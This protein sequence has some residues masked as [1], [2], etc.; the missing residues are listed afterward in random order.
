[1][2]LDHPPPSPAAG[3]GAGAAARPAATGS[4]RS[5]SFREPCCARPRGCTM[6]AQRL[7]T[8]RRRWRANSTAATCRRSSAPTATRDA[9][10][11]D[12]RGLAAATASPTG[13]CRSTGWSRARS[14]V[15]GRSQGA[16]ARAP[17][18]P[19]TTAS[20]AGARSASGPA[21]RSGPVLD[22]GRAA[23]ARRA[24]SSSTAP[25]LRDGT[26]Y[27]ESIDLVDA[28]HPQTILAY[29]M[30]GTPLPIAQ[31]RAAAPRVERQLG[32]KHAKYRDADRGG[33]EP[34]RRS[35]RQRR[36]LGG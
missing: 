36:L 35:R 34:R 29:G 9:A 4:S 18:S 11:A 2:S 15:A 25:T 20:R 16:A 31:R 14:P 10:D 30:N 33:R 13:G 7:I 3:L 17:R 23:A 32:Y 5:P 28:F 21:C 26:P 22:A 12:Y 24:S 6:R 1:M 27:Y 19:A 8:D